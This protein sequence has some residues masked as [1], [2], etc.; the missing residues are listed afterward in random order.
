MDW[1]NQ[2]PLTEPLT[3]AQLVYETHV[4][5]TAKPGG[6]TLTMRQFSCLSRR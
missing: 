3:E 2:W 6:V 1:L 4:M 5:W